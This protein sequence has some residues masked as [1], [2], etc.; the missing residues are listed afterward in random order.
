MKHTSLI[1]ALLLSLCGLFSLV[2]EVSAGTGGKSD[3]H[4]L[5]EIVVSGAREGVE[6]TETVRT[7]TAAEIAASGARSLDQAIALLPGVNIRTGGEGV[8]RIDVRGFR[9]RHVVLLLDGIPMNSAFDQQFNPAVIPTENIAAI[10]LTSGGSSVLY[11]QGGL[12]GVINIITKK[13]TSGLQGEVAGETGDLQPYQ[14]RFGLSGASDRLDYFLSGSALKINGFPLAGDFRA[15][16]GQGSGY[17]QGSD[18]ERR[19]LFCSVGFTPNEALSMNL[20][21]G[22]SAGEQGKPAS[23]I[24]DPFDPFASPPKYGR[25][26]D[27]SGVSAQLAADYALT[28]RFSLRGWAFSN[29]HEEE[30]N[31]YDNSSF[32]SFNQVAGSFR[33]QVTTTIDGVSLQPKYELGRGGVVTVSL[34]AEADRWKNSG[35]LTTAPNSFTPLAA[36]RSLS[37]YTASVEYAL[38]PL[39]NLGLVAGYGHHW[40]LRDG[41]NADDYSLL[42]GASYDLSQQARVKASFKRAIR[43]PSL[44]D[45]YDLSQGNPELSAERSSTYEVGVEQKL[46]GRSL[47]SLTGFYTRAKNLI[48]NDQVAGR[49]MNLAEVVFAGIEVG[50]ETRFLAKLLLRGSYSYLDS[51]DKSRA[52]RE[53]QQYTPAHKLALE[54]KYDFDFGF[55]PYVSFRYVGRQF[56]YTKN[57]VTPVQKSRLNDYSL[58][59]VKLSQAFMEKRVSLYIGADNLFDTNYETSYG[60]PQPG[61]FVYG[62]AECR[63]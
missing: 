19:N 20:T 40:Q 43:F 61:R 45:L 24:S 18:R 44:G 48:Q 21:L 31:Q 16:A 42:A 7:V 22:Y 10:K 13:G 14:A 58:V 29:H 57:N 53:E 27:F 8:P 39:E 12:G 3:G 60:F 50:A 63:F 25:S 17:R 59:N 6:A 5:G 62:G 4:S 2:T 28:E 47:F 23:S 35:T 46:P 56:F 33:Q 55:T 36:R 51:Q 11:G 49:N 37:L 54:G 26:D 38:S 30:S 32:N 34:A 41:S 9:T 1:P 15:T 52:G